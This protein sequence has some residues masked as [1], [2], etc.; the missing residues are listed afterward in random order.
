MP[1]KARIRD[2]ERTRRVILDAAEAVF[3]ERGFSAGALSEIADQASVT[4][5]LIHHHFGTKRDLWM[6]VAER[7]FAANASAQ[8]EILSRS[9]A[10]PALLAEATRAYFDF[11]RSNPAIVRLW[12]WGNAER[13]S[14]PYL[15]TGNELT[16]TVLGLIRDLAAGGVVRDDLDPA[17][18]L[19]AF[20]SLIEHW[21][22]AEE[23]FRIR[24]GDDMPS[25][26][27]YL[28]VLAELFLKGIVR[29]GT[30]RPEEKRL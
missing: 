16:R 29:P 11:Q 5:S 18:M 3:A 24:F 27:A 10:P 20:F 30:D 28:R 2:P 26:D 13:I 4:K 19:A 17:A 9:A 12:A 14:W 7:L 23:D 25:D 6:A 1:A 15:D 8:S 22:Q 21:F